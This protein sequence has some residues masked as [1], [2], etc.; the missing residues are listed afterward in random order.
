M[1]VYKLGDYGFLCTVRPGD[2]LA[3]TPVGDKVCSAIRLV[4]LVGAEVYVYLIFL[5]GS[6]LRGAERTC[7]PESIDRTACFATAYRPR[8]IR[9]AT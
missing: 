6:I 4:L 8:T 3:A 2:P 1:R 5:F 7:N 9:R